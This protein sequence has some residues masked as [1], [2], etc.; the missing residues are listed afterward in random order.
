MNIRKRAG[1]VG[2]ATLFGLPFAAASVGAMFSIPAS[3]RDNKWGDVLAGAFVGALI[4]VIGFGILGVV[5]IQWSWMAAMD[6]LRGANPDKQWLWRAD[7]AAGRADDSA[8]RKARLMWF[9]A[10]LWAVM[11]APLLYFRPKNVAATYNYAAFLLLIFPAASI[12]WIYGALRYSKRWR[13]FGQS[14]F[15]MA[16]VPFST[17]GAVAGAVEFQKPFSTKV[18]FHLELT[19][20]KSFKRKGSNGKS[21]KEEEDLWSDEAM[22]QLDARGMLPVEFQLPAN[23]RETD[24][25]Q[26]DKQISWQLDVKAPV[27]R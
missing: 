1:L 22:V 6:R 23:A 27:E 15:V 3:L 4:G 9:F 14:S 16:S 7:W 17:G 8:H 18:E 12:G 19:C 5:T 26:S 11:F 10:V 21:Y 13:K 20:T 24:I 2:L 25:R